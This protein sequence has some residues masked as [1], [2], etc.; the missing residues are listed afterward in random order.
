MLDQSRLLETLKLDGLF[1]TRPSN[2]FY[3]CGF[4]GTNGFVLL[5]EKLK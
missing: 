5:T 1:V 4:R 2:I 3:L